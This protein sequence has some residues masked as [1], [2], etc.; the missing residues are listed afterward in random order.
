MAAPVK[1]EPCLDLSDAPSS[2]AAQRALAAAL[3]RRQP[4]GDQA[5]ADTASA[6][7][8]AM[9]A[10]LEALRMHN[11]GLELQLASALSEARRA[12]EA[13]AELRH[14]VASLHG[15]G[16]A[17]SAAASPLVA[18]GAW[19]SAP[20]PDPA[21]ARPVRRE[22]RLAASAAAL[23][24]G[25]L[26]AGA[27]RRHDHHGG[28]PSVGSA[29]SW[30]G[31]LLGEPLQP[32]ECLMGD[33]QPHI[34][35]AAAAGVARWRARPHAQRGPPPAAAAV[36][37][38]DRVAA[39]TGGAYSAWAAL[40]ARF[41]RSCAAGGPRPGP[42]CF[43][44]AAR[45]R[46]N[47]AAPSH[48][49]PFLGCV[50]PGLRL[51]GPPASH[52]AAAL[53]AGRLAMP[54]CEG[55][56]HRRRLA[57]STAPPGGD[58]QRQR[59]SS[60]GG[61]GGGGQ[62]GSVTARAAASA[63]WDQPH[64]HGAAGDARSH[65]HGDEGGSC[66]C[67]G[68]GGGGEH[69]HA[70]GHGHGHGAHSHGAHSHGAH[71]R[72]HAHGH[73]HGH[74]HH[75]GAGGHHH[76][77]HTDSAALSSSPLLSAL[78]KTGLFG[79]AEHL[80]HHTAYTV[81]SV[82]AFVAAL[83]LRLA[84]AQGLLTAATAAL[85][86]KAALGVTFALSGVP[87]LAETLGAAAAGRV[88]THVLMSASVLGTLYMGMAQEGALLLLLFRVSHLLEDRLTAKA[89]GG[90]QRLF[91]SVPDTAALVEV[92]PSGAPRAA[93][94]RQVR[95]LRPP[96]AARRARRARPR[97]APRRA[98]RPRPTAR[99]AA[100][101][102]AAGAGRGRRAG[103]HVLVRPGEQVP[104]DGTIS[105]GTAN[106]S[107]QHIS[108]EEQPVRLGPGQEVPAGSL[109]TDG[110]LVVRVQATAADSTPARI[111][112]MAAQAQAARPQLTRWLDGVGAVWSKAV[113]GATLATAA[114]LPLLGVPFLGDRG[115]LYR[116]MGVLTAGSPCALALVPLAYA[117]AIAAITG[118]G[119]LIKSGAAL[120]ALAGVRTVALDKTGTIT[121]GSL[122]L[123]EGYALEL[124]TPP[125]DGAPAAGGGGGGVRAMAGLRE[126]CA[127]APP[128]RGVAAAGGALGTTTGF[129]AEADGA[130]G[131]DG[132][133][134]AD[135]G[136]DALAL[137]CAVALSRL[138]NHPVSRAMVDSAPGLDGGVAVLSFEQVPGAG[139]QGVCRVGGG[140][141]LHVR[142]GAADW[143]GAQLDGAAGAAELGGLLRQHSDRPSRATAL[144]SIN[145]ALRGGGG[146]GGGGPGSADMAVVIDDGDGG[147]ASPG[148][149]GSA[150]KAAARLRGSHTNRDGSLSFE[151]D[152]AA[153]DASSAPGAAGDAAGASVAGGAG[154][155]GG[156]AGGAG[157]PR[158]VVLLCFD[159][160]IQ[161]GVP[162]A[163]AAL[164]RGTWAR[165]W[166][167]RWLG[168]GAG[169]AKA[170]VMLTGGRQPARRGGGRGR[171]G[172]RRLPGGLRPED[173]LAYV[174]AAAAH[175]A[176]ADAA[177]GGARRGG[178]ARAPGGL[179][180]AGDGINDAPAL[181]AAQVGVA[182]ASTPKD[183]VAAAADIIVLNGQGVT[184]LPWLFHVADRTH[185]ILKQPRVAA[186]RCCA[187]TAPGAR[188][189][190]RARNA[191]ADAAQTAVI[192][193][194]APAGSVVAITG[195]SFA[196]YLAENELVL[197]DYYTQWCGP[198]KMIAPH[199]EEMAQQ[200]KGVKF[201]KL[202]CTTDAEAK[203]I[204]MAAGIKALPTFQMFRNGERVGVFVGSKHVQLR[205]FVED[206]AR[207]SMATGRSAERGAAPPGACV[208]LPALEALGEAAWG[209]ALVPKLLADRG[210]APAFA[211]ACR[212]TRRVVHGAVAALKLPG[213]DCE[214]AAAL[215]GGLFASCARVEVTLA[216][217]EDAA[218]GLAAA[219]PALATLPQLTALGLLVADRG[220][221]K[222]LTLALVLGT[223]RYGLP[224]LRELELG[225]AAGWAGSDAAWRALGQAT[226]LT[227]ITV[228]F[229]K[230]LKVPVS[231]THCSAL[232]QLSGLA[233]LE[234]SGGRF[235][236]SPQQQYDW[237]GGLAPALTVLR[238]PLVC[239]RLGLA[240]V[241]ACT[242]LRSL[243][244]HPWSDD[245]TGEAVWPTL[246]GDEC[247][248]LARLVA[249]TELWLPVKQ[250]SDPRLLAVLGALTDL[251]VLSVH[252][253]SRASLPCLAGLSRLT[254]L[255]GE[256]VEGGEGAAVACPS[257]VELWGRG[258]VPF[259][260]FPC[261]QTVGQ[262]ASWSPATLRELAEH[263][264]EL[265]LCVGECGG[266]AGV[267]GGGSG[268]D[269]SRPAAARR[270]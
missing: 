180:M 11:S 148:A 60:G 51:G 7:Q 191:A 154:G 177:A 22:L 192:D 24:A 187:P 170:V 27:A 104:L 263:C 267:V 6:E 242:Q 158:G 171:G 255:V 146:L 149:G 188:R 66:G 151:F 23:A 53:P 209:A 138:S 28:R 223:V 226:Q 137:G 19:P 100:A 173:K 95:A 36:A 141:P 98:A 234:V 236:N 61:G 214:R 32:E 162:G 126:L 109:S 165:G 13:N 166:R 129:G 163:V 58:E 210:S 208:L 174:T 33:E 164:Q 14:L 25:P 189:V 197:V 125:S 62:R 120:D 121:T 199:L 16:G 107:L 57:S 253:L 77:F 235:T 186:G 172:H 239:S 159:D 245:I 127:R 228:R 207:S 97:P 59:S 71:G 238:L 88:D 20:A 211:L 142:F 128:P 196:S 12:S 169:D 106:L 31:T 130:G 69:S 150:G 47:G 86:A 257:V 1:A 54:R 247:A 212:A 205:K 194:D 123:A 190:V 229:R 227:A 35:S 181:A 10:E 225:V 249:L 78:A 224:G 231:L 43:A 37:A 113:I 2:P 76:H 246:G 147:G 30:P 4:A 251:R 75:H 105:W 230:G 65:G 182:I 204:A 63:T 176:A 52:A 222:P 206:T 91:D 200:I 254:Q 82:S 48:R 26:G 198:C 134:A 155:A 117:C 3:K 84:A 56:Q 102:A 132:G 133:G 175:A 153:P 87:Q 135:G 90:L 201:A 45:R 92:E 241:G 96:R 260:A 143:V 264:S 240:S 265:Q 179:L 145:D 64:D 83:L 185:T 213:G 203:K 49:A 50:R 140:P 114:L 122:S 218:V 221:S 46:C 250:G 202:D 116:A 131:A 124:G 195:A 73:A 29:A 178:L 152:V 99:T 118:R 248:A 262:R 168:P 80:E 160:V 144:L 268:A 15:V 67:G 111:A 72:G 266:G 233:S 184:S 17:A 136:F 167:A 89:A 93:T 220:A 270:G 243:F 258:P 110:L 157:A 112:Q 161:P 55:L 269:R 259:A 108:G 156:G 115:A 219:L 18:G 9:Q 216:S 8:R 103:Q 40:T 215:Q 183:M 79:L 193:A 70:E 252:G 21:D 44:A 256:W 94:A 42:S 261:L 68:G 237:L 244:L 217:R 232:T 5:R 119:I 139:V 81:A 85:L 41:G 101:A 74:H 38:A 39:R 34:S